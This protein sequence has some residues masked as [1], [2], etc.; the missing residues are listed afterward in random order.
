MCIIRCLRKIYNAY[1]H[2]ITKNTLRS[3]QITAIYNVTQLITA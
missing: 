2:N 1:A 3:L